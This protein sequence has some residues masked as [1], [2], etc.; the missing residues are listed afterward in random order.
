MADNTILQ[1][2]TQDDLSER[3]RKKLNKN[4]KSIKALINKCIDIAADPYF[5]FDV[6]YPV[7]C[8]IIT[9]DE[10]DPRLAR[11]TWKKIE[12]AFLVSAGAT[13]ENNIRYEEEPEK[14]VVDSVSGDGVSYSTTTIHGRP[15]C[16]CRFVYERTM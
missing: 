11:G 9:N 8:W 5:H 12:D 4:F 14:T 10:N 6:L 1:M 15:A 7:G 13:H 3:S 2:E 16:E